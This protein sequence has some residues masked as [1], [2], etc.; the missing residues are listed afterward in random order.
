M[1]NIVTH[2]CNNKDTNFVHV[3]K[4]KSNKCLEA[5]SSDE[6]AGIAKRM[7]LMGCQLL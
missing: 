2:L 3:C 4:D 1:C 7:T 6:C 5:K